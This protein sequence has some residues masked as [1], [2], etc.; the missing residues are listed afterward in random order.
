MMINTRWLAVLGVLT[1]LGCGSG[2]ETSPG[3][4]SNNG[5]AGQGGSSGGEAGSGN[6][7]GGEG[8]SGNA[9]GGEAG[10]GNAGGEPG[11]CETAQD[12]DDGIACTVE[13]CD[14]GTCSFAND[15]AKC[16]D[17]LYCNGTET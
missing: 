8:G 9:G 1:V 11:R 10:S 4:T 2:G 16:D 6:A 12:C 14:G 15:D 5:G 13:S 7:G 3:T 17:A